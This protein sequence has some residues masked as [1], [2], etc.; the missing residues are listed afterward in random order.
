MTRPKES[1][2]GMVS[3]AIDFLQQRELIL[4]TRRLNETVREQSKL[5][6]QQ[7]SDRK[8]DRSY[9]GSPKETYEER[10]K[11]LEHKK[12][13]EAK[14]LDSFFT[15]LMRFQNDYPEY[16]YLVLG[17][18]IEEGIFSTQTKKISRQQKKLKINGVDFEVV[19]RFRTIVDD[20]IPEIR[21][22]IS[23]TAK[24]IQSQSSGARKT[25]F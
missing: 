17:M 18:F 11:R 3:S 13:V 2:F 8:S 9:Q 25:R 16:V 7:S 19:E 23:D 15:Y 6:G 10:Q 22:E 20:K 1:L 5:L 14:K 12:K 24:H 21:R 4:Q